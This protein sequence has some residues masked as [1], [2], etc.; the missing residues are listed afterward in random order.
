M[1]TINI[2]NSKIRL[3][4]VESYKQG[5]KRIYFDNSLKETLRYQELIFM[6]LSSSTVSRSE[7]LKVHGISG[8]VDIEKF[9]TYSELWVMQTSNKKYGDSEEYDNA[10]VKV[11]RAIASAFLPDHVSI[12]ESLL[13]AV[14]DKHL[15]KL[16]YET[17]GMRGIEKFKYLLL[18]P[19]TESH[20]KFTPSI[21]SVYQRTRRYGV[22]DLIND[23]VSDK[24]YI[25][26][27]PELIKKYVPITEI[28]KTSGKFVYSDWSQIVGKT[29][30][31]TRA[32][33]SLSFRGSIEVSVPENEF[34]I[35]SGVRTLKA[36][37]SF[38]I[39]K[40]GTLWT[41]MLGV[42]TLNKKL[43]SKIRSTGA[44]EMELGE[45]EYFINL[46]KLPLVGRSF[47]RRISPESLFLPEINIR[48]SGMSSCYIRRLKWMSEKGIHVWPKDRDEVEE[49][50]SDKFLHG[51]GIYG[52]TYR[53]PHTEKGDELGMTYTSCELIKRVNGLPIN[54]YNHLTSYI[55]KGRCSNKVINRMCSELDKELKSSSYDVI[56]EKLEEKRK[57]WNDIRVMNNFR[58]ILSKNLT[59]DK[60][61]QHE[62]V[63]IPILINRDRLEVMVEVRRKD[64]SV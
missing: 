20:D 24:S 35:E 10:D 26:T 21:T 62:G 28:R 2:K 11:I 23:L 52:D 51:L 50:E 7:V 1:D 18:S 3:I 27:D 16:F 12:V 47:I 34:G 19:I 30:N 58:F 57:Y 55:N 38:C 45:N 37:R 60:P 49:S 40:D 33:L 9:S 31:T 32:N 56:L 15:L 39:I 63:S 29:T 8:F 36:I 14:G 4:R 6:D 17:F 59:F 64:Y 22:L 5:D 54:F 61:K 25:L 53:P 43:V 42:R 41:P 44:I 13:Q 46:T 48:L